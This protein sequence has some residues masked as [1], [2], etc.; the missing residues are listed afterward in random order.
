V[1]PGRG[2]HLHEVDARGAQPRLAG[3]DGIAHHVGER[4]MAAL[5]RHGAARDAREI[6][7]VVDKA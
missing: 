4:H 1:A 7:Q 3:L 5:Q 6:Q 2:I